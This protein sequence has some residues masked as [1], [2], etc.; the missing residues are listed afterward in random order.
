ME[1]NTAT[2]REWAGLA[3]LALP[4]LLVSVD[5]FVLLLA[6]PRLSQELH[7][8]SIQ[9]LWISDI[10]GFLL[11]GFLVTMGTLG[12]RIGRR[13]VLLAGASAFGAASVL[14]AYASSPATLIAAR[15]T[16]GVAGAALSPSTL[17]LIG[18][19]FRQ[20][21]QRA[22]AIGVWMACFMSGAAIGPLAGGVMLAHFWWGSVFL[23]A[24]PTMALLLILGPVLL[25][26]YRDA[27]ARRLDLGS[28]ALSLAAI[29]PVVYGLTELARAGWRPLPA[30]ALAAGIALGV[31][32][33][34]R[35]R[36]LPE[37]LLDLRL[38]RNRS[39]TAA[40]GGMT[41]STMLTGAVMLLVTQYFELV[42]GLSPVRAGLCMLPAAVTM[43][44][45]SLIA[46]RLT[47]RVRPAYVIA[48]GLVVAIAGLLLIS[49]ASGLTPVVAGWALITL[50]SGPMVVLSVDMVIGAA[51]PARAGSAAA[52]NET[53]SQLGFALG[54]AILGSVAS[55]VYRSRIA[56]L[57]RGTPPAAASA[58]RESLAG[59]VS[60]A[61]DLAPRIAAS[62]LGQSR[63]AFTAGMHM[64]AVTSAVLLAGV[65]LT[66]I[67]TLRQVRPDGQPAPGTNPDQHSVTTSTADALR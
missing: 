18:T 59:A 31:V 50:G 48:A 54:I 47:L 28:V 38:L 8:S 41:L 25:P 34:R 64:T 39:F 62:L 57:P 11:A 17:A 10:Y 61:H 6:L 49:Q 4:T 63:A 36:S 67:G 22:T 60:A 42:R 5:V 1:S 35:Q 14:A 44:V 23:L 43:T 13:R 55:A 66:V 15:A 32:F 3:V 27:G 16:L 26:E 40:M 45:S 46:P 29:L 20:P 58:G 51:P 19:M 65:A 52:L 2:R 30:L 9:Q 33:V 12:D 24:V 56:V 53:G 37:P 21:R 7:A